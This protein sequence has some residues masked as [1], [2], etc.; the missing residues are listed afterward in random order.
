VGARK[1][2]E[3][4]TWAPE[5]R[6]QFLADHVGGPVALARMLEVS[7]SQPTRW[8]S[9]EESPGIVAAQR[10]IGL[11]AVVAQLLLLWDSEI[12][13]DWLTSPNGHLDGARPIDVLK[14][15]GPAEVL[16]AVAAQASGAFA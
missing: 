10:I 3:R 12:V 1:V 11:E 7:P 4:S 5:R 15:R 13:P 8:R 14:L 6:V 9:G 2:R 16:E